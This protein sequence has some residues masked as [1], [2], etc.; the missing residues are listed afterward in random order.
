MYCEFINKSW[1][2]W[3][4]R[5][6]SLDCIPQYKVEAKNA[7]DA[8]AS[9]FKLKEQVSKKKAK[10]IVSEKAKVVYKAKIEKQKIQARNIPVN[11]LYVWAA[12][13]NK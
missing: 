1:W 10:V 8:I 13:L 3:S 11:G 9:V 7:V 4:S 6:A 2:V 12:N 5:R